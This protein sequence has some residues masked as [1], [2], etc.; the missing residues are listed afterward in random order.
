MAR[1]IYPVDVKDLVARLNARDGGTLLSRLGVKEDD[2]DD[3]KL[4][5]IVWGV[6]HGGFPVMGDGKTFHPGVDIGLPDVA[7]NGGSSWYGSDVYA[8][9]DGEVIYVESDTLT[10]DN[11]DFGRVVVRHQTPEGDVYA[12]YQH[13]IG[14]T[15]VWGGLVKQGEVLGQVGWHGDFPHLHFGLCSKTK[16]GGDQDLIPEADQ[17]A[18][19]EGEGV[20]NVL[21]VKTDALAPAEWPMVPD[22]PAYIYNP[23]ELIRYH[24]GEEYLHDIGGGHLSRVRLSGKPAEETVKPNEDNTH[25]VESHLQSKVLKDCKK[26]EELSHDFE[27]P[28]IGRSYSDKEVIKALQACLKG[29][30][31]DVGRFGPN[32][33]GIDG[34][35]GKTCERIVKT[36]QQKLKLQEKLLASLGHDAADVKES[37]AIDALTLLAMDAAGAALDKEAEKKPE[38]APKKEELATAPAKEREPPPKVTAPPSAWI[39]DAKGKKQSVAF[40]LRMYQAL[41]RWRWTSANDPEVGTGYS[42]A[43]EPSNLLVYKQ[44]YDNH[45][46]GGYLS[47]WPRMDMFPFLVGDGTREL[48][49]GGSVNTFSVFN[50]TWVAAGFSNCCNVQLAALFVA[51]GGRDIVVQKDGDALAYWAGAHDSKRYPGKTD[52]YVETPAKKKIRAIGAFEGIVVG[53]DPP[54]VNRGKKASC[55]LATQFLGLGDAIPVADGKPYNGE[56]TN[57]QEV[58]RYVRIGDWANY[59][60]HSWLVGEI[61][62][63]IWFEGGLKKVKPEAFVDQSSL[64][65]DSFSGLVASAKPP[66]QAGELT[67]DQCDWISKHEEAWNGRIEG[68]YALAGSGD[69]QVGGSKKKVAKVE[70]DRLGVFSANGL[71][72][73]ENR[74]IHGKVYHFKDAYKA[75][76]KQIRDDLTKAKDKETHKQKQNELND[77]LRP[78]ERWEDRS[79]KYKEYWLSRG[80]TN[81]LYPIK[82]DDPVGFAR[83]FAHAQG[84]PASNKLSG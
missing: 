68:L 13:L 69:I 54:G 72:G 25:K 51:L 40:G 9:D 61:R 19:P 46:K 70:V 76:L 49:D 62:Y 22:G 63:G 55:V 73:F 39:F 36:F 45:V 17:G 71:W 10:K 75:E 47:E 6:G 81:A 58:L 52:Q 20:W 35:Y 80:V 33:D 65:G 31:Y 32:H 24:R 79:D 26:L 15:A 64:V 66:A 60:H 42:A 82:P 21:R 16:F 57:K 56:Y 29:L 74:A 27:F 77:A 43:A 84:A 83:F 11:Y 2:R 59:D 30:G 44:E 3:Q 38:A 8:I 7:S 41:M 5:A 34:D 1:F 50:V 23:V 4:T 12:V 28:A 53:N 67:D 37:G 48:T 78:A 14:V 18:L